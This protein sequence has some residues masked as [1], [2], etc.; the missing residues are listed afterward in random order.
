MATTNGNRKILDLKRWEFCTPAPQ[1]TAAS[2]LIVSSRH[3]RQQQLLVTATTNAQLY[4]PSEDGWVTVPL[5]RLRPLPPGACG[6]AGS[7]S[8]GATAG[9]S[10]LTATAGSTTTITTN[11]TLARDLRG[12]SVYFVGGT[13]AGKLKT[14]AE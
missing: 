13:N 11:Q 1:A 14:I 12:Y 9:A 6:T 5:R 2:H 3:Y 4:N 10:S 8:T 7:F